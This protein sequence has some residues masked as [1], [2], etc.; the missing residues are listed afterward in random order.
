MLD[1]A[2]RPGSLMIEIREAHISDRQ[3]STKAP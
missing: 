2:A 3:L 1:D